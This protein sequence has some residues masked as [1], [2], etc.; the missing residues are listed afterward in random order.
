MCQARS[1]R[2]AQGPPPGCRLFAE[3]PKPPVL[4]SPRSTS[5]HEPMSPWA[6][7]LRRS[8]PRGGDAEHRALASWR[9]CGAAG[10]GGRGYAGHESRRKSCIYSAGEA[11]HYADATREGW[12]QLVLSLKRPSGPHGSLGLFSMR[13]RVS[14]PLEE[15][16]LEGISTRRASSRNVVIPWLRD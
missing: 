15:H 9:A 6:H 4:A 11:G 2:N 7:K 10:S 8:C 3:L 5:S 14:W 1:P 16:F 13:T 12:R